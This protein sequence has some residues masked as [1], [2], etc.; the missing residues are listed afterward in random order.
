MRGGGILLLIF[1][2][3]LRNFGKFWK[4]LASV[5]SRKQVGSITILSTEARVSG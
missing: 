5:G 2:P 1:P 4:Q 3:I